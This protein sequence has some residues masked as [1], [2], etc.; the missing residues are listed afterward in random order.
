MLPEAVG[1]NA[2]EQFPLQRSPSQ[3]R[4]HTPSKPRLLPTTGPDKSEEQP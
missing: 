3:Q 1:V 4:A 2:E